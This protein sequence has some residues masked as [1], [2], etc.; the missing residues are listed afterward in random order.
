MAP[1][2]RGPRILILTGG[3]RSEPGD[4]E[5]AAV[6]GLAADLVTMAPSAAVT[7]LVADGHLAVPAVAA[8]RTAGVD[9]GVGPD[10]WETWAGARAY[11]FSHLIVTQSAAGLVATADV[12][13]AQ[14][15]AALVLHIGSRLGLPSERLVGL[16]PTTPTSELDGLAAVAAAAD[17]RM[18]AAVREADAV[19]CEHADDATWLAARC[20]SVPVVYVPPVLP[21]G[22]PVRPAS[23]RTGI[24]ILADRGHD[25]AAG[26]EAAALTLLGS[27]VPALRRRTPDLDVRI[28]G[29]RP[30]PQLRA[31]ARRAGADFL[32]AGE[33]GP[34]FA[35]SRLAL[36]GRGGRAAAAT[37]RWAMAT[38]TPV[39][40]GTG[41]P[42][43]T[44][45]AMTDP[46]PSDPNPSDPDPSDANPMVGEARRLLDDDRAWSEAQRTLAT[47]AG[48]DHDGSLRTRR[49]AGALMGLGIDPTGTLAPVVA[50]TPPVLPWR[51]TP[52]ALRPGDDPPPVDRVVWGP[53][54]SQ[55][56]PSAPAP[57]QPGTGRPSG[58]GG[59]YGDRDVAYRR[60]VDR[61]GPTKA[62]LDAFRADRAEAR[63]PLPPT[64]FVLVVA[65]GPD[66]EPAALDATLRTLVTQVGVEALVV[67]AAVP[68][69][70]E[71]A[72]AVVERYTVERYTVEG[73]GGR[74]RVR[75]VVLPE[76]SSAP[77]VQ[78]AI[79]AVLQDA[80]GCHVGVLLPG[81]TYKPHA[82]A[83]VAR[84]I[85]G[86]PEAVEAIYADED[87]LDAEGRLVEMPGKPDWSPNTLLS[88]GY[89]GRMVLVHR[90]VLL[91]I[92]GVS[93]LT[94][95]DAPGG[96]AGPDALFD[97]ALE[98][99]V[100]RVAEQTDRIAH[101]PEPLLTRRRTG[102]GPDGHG[103]AGGGP[104]PAA[105]L[106]RAV[107][108]AALRRRRRDRPGD[109]DRGLAP[110]LLR[111]RYPW[112]GTPRV[113]VIVPTHDA[114]QLLR[115]CLTSVL[116]RSTY[117]R[118]EVVVV[119]NRTADPEALA[120]LAG[121]PGPVLRYPHP[122]NYARMMNFAAGQVDADV[123][124]FLNNDTEVLTP[125]WVE[126]MLE[127]ALR[128]E[129]GA[130]GARL[131]FPDR[132]PQHEGILLGAGGWAH[133][134]RHQGLWSRG[135]TVRDTS[136]VTG[137]CLMMRRTVFEQV[138]G[139]DEQLRIAYNDIDL[140]LRIRQAGYEIVYTPHAQLLHDE[141]STRRTFEHPEEAG[142]F[143]RRWH[144]RDRV[145]P[146]YGP[147]YLQE[148]PF[149]RLDLRP[150]PTP[151]APTPAAPGPAAPGPAAG[152]RRIDT[153]REAVDP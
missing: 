32:P 149:F 2:D 87:G 107:A 73:Y 29:D 7:L 27:V 67:V 144:V 54:P 42:V 4:L 118:L 91:R 128:P 94:H 71:A 24:V 39:L 137:A 51:Q 99:L 97:V 130:V 19:W 127:H 18:L 59:V 61:R 153:V 147:Q 23:A 141:G 60:W 8:L 37:R 20:R 31:A 48:V 96:R 83:A 12:R 142:L 150:V 126:A 148:H 47:E 70:A 68:S 132:S 84:W 52:L 85:D 92:R 136:A 35:Q 62:T 74:G 43:L 25:T 105:G 49:L 146:Y 138:G 133:N 101:I 30:S 95:G 58:P 117:P 89:T 123:F 50:V 44:G 90:D 125:D 122:F 135:E 81:D 15:Q 41:T 22:P 151:V 14:P 86:Q 120:V 3:L 112:A 26:D 13:R 134:L 82:L 98:D 145:D 53:L 110:G 108:A 140:C 66:D 78:P 1:P 45:T 104:G 100:L 33:V 80:A 111:A 64:R 131:W 10:D 28:V 121:L 69:A 88:S 76:G 119:D 72:A 114:P 103:P 102:L 56:A 116:G 143:E 77:L 124:V 57:S 106:R 34:A 129:V 93:T 16:G 17:T 36:D 40:T 21:V 11:G 63:A 152:S 79:G 139:N 5:S 65:V 55:P 9:V 115:T 75:L 46:D 113:A 38:A 109:V 6:R